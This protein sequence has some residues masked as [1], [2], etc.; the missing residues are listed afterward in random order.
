MDQERSVGG[1]STR[2]GSW[3]AWALV[4][5]SAILFVGGYTL[6]RTAGLTDLRVRNFGALD[7]ILTFAILL[8]FAVVGAIVASQRPSNPIGWI[9]S[10]MGLLVGLG[11][12]ARGYAES[13]SASDFGP[14]SLG[15][16]AAWFGSWSWTILVF[17][18][19][20]FLLLLFPDGRLPSPRW[21]PVAWVAGLGITGFV[22]SSALVAGP[23]GD[24]PQIVNP[25]GVDSL[26]VGVV[27]FAA[28]V[29]AVS[30]MVASAVSVIVRHRHAGSEQRQQIKWLAYGGAVVVGTIFVAGA[31]ALWN[32]YVG[33]LAISVALLGLPVSTGI[34]SVRHR[35]YDIDLIINRT[36]V[37]STLTAMLVAVYFG[38]VVVLQYVLRAL[39]G[40]ESQLAI[41]ASTLAIAAVFNPL[42]RFS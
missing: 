18:P 26:V 30:S 34:A 5:L 33:I 21:R 2:S 29:V 36:L 40:G 8:T 6:S 7:V 11:I 16:T 42:E 24:F 35:L 20:S 37:Y 9:F 12:F 27:T 41:V 25:Y 15:E 22:V 17:V 10:T 31:V 38:G 32:E 28:A 13:W 19:T 14:R 39:T 23:L 1:I 3:L 4:V